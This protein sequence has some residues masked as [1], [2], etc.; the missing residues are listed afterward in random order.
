MFVNLYNAL[1]AWWSAVNNGLKLGA[2]RA[3]VSAFATPAEVGAYLM[4]H[5]AYTGDPLGGAA[6][7]FLHPE[8]LQAAM[9]E[10][11]EALKRL[12]IDCDDYATWAYAALSKV[13]GCEP[14]IYT[15][16]DTGL[17]GS[18]V[19]CAYTWRFRCGV[20]DTNGHRELPDLSERTLCD[21][22]TAIYRT[23]GYRYVS[24]TVT[25]YPF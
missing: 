15:L 19:V 9:N 11:P 12:S 1:K 22:F 5:A 2:P 13:P 4:A 10:G 18:H 21:V 8:R 6:D 23:R 24:A 25:P 17:V 7:F 20:I 14:R 3:P 16:L